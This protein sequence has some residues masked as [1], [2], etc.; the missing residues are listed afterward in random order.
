MLLSSLYF[1]DN[2]HNNFHFP[3]GMLTLTLFDVAAITG[4]RPIGDA[5]N[6][7]YMIENTIGFDGNRGTFTHYVSDHHNKDTEEVSDE[8]HIAL[9]ALWLYRC[10]FCSKS[11]QVAKKFLIMA[12]QLHVGHK[13][14]IDQMILGCLYESLGDGFETLKKIQLGSNILLTGPYWLLQ[15]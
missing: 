7:N 11:L 14:Y 15:L 6:P 8:E 9:L 1:W 10:I 5:F 13:L 4:L 3:C 12:N 2:T